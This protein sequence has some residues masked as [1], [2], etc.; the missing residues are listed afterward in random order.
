MSK[1]NEFQFL[2][3]VDQETIIKYLE[4]LLDGF[5]SG[6]INLKAKEEAIILDPE[7]LMK[8]EIEAKNKGGRAKVQFKVSWKDHPKVVINQSDLNIASKA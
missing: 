4:A 8:L 6:H 3:L 2:S 1:S 5:K 7:G